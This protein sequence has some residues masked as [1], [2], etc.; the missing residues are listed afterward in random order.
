MIRCPNCGNDLVYSPIPPLFLCLERM[1]GDIITIN[2][3]CK[4]WIAENASARDL[5]R[6]TDRIENLAPMLS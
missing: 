1:A 3:R 4:P 2:M 5:L 6:M